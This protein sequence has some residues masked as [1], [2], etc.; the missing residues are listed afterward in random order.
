MEML[1]PE[2]LV[3]DDDARVTVEAEFFFKRVDGLDALLR[4]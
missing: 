2:L 4:R 3:H 1:R